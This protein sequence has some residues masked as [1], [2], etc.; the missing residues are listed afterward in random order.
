M[1]HGGFSPLVGDMIR[2]ILDLSLS[3]GLLA[4]PWN[5]NEYAYTQM[6]MAK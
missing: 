6:E 1:G 2:L 3:N 4:S 5:G